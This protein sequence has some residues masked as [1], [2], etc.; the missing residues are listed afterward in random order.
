MPHKRIKPFKQ[1][2]LK[3]AQRFVHVSS[4]YL[5][6]KPTWGQVILS[7]EDFSVL[8]TK[9]PDT[10]FQFQVLDSTDKP[11]YYVK[12]NS[13][14]LSAESSLLCKPYWFKVNVFYDLVTHNDYLL[15]EYNLDNVF[16]DE[17]DNEK[18]S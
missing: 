12:I 6:I 14:I 9:Y 11:S 7:E 17:M 18:S 1:Y 4:Y 13:S 5:P 16:G 3:G 15:L 2:N 10:L 8:K